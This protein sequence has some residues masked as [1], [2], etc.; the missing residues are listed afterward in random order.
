[1]SMTKSAYTKPCEICGAT[2][3]RP[4]YANGKM[5]NSIE[6]ANRSWCSPKCHTEVRYRKYHAVYDGYKTA[7]QHPPCTHCGK[8]VGPREGEIRRAWRARV[9]CSAACRDARRRMSKGNPGTLQRGRS[10]KRS[11]RKKLA[12]DGYVFDGKFPTPAR[13]KSGWVSVTGPDTGKV[14]TSFVPPRATRCPTTLAALAS[15]VRAHPDLGT[16]LL[17]ELTDSWARQD[18]A[19]YHR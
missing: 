18:A 2:F 7:Y 5:Q 12:N 10:G 4:R 15:A 16:A 9:T 13:M 6:W 8:P 1:M 14:I 17:G 11:E 3:E 19:A